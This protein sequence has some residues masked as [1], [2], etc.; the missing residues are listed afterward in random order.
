MGGLDV[1]AIAKITA[2]TV[3]L[4]SAAQN[5]DK[6]INY[7]ADD[8]QANIRKKKNLLEQQLASRRAGVAAMGVTGSK[9]AAA[10]QERI[11]RETYDDIEDDNKIYQRQYE[12]L[13]EAKNSRLNQAILSSV[14]SD[15]NKLIK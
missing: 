3:S 6:K 9:S 4:V 13:E 7:L 15:S 11:A 8:Q 5:T 12:S 1:A 2:A 14:W 10:V